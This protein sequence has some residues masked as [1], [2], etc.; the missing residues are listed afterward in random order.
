MVTKSLWCWN[1][2]WM[3]AERTRRLL[4]FN[5]VQLTRGKCD[6]LWLDEEESRLG[7]CSTE[8][9]GTCLWLRVPKVNWEHSET[10]YKTIVL[11][12]HNGQGFLFFSGHPKANAMVSLLGDGLVI[13][14]L[15]SMAQI[16]EWFFL[17]DFIFLMVFAVCLKYL[18]LC[19][20]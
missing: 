3:A 8:K 6:G 18:W 17:F 5:S 1:Y 4:K 11:V 12:C 7:Y 15:I 10:Y 14:H 16:Y 19:L 9:A 2:S 13:L 20:V